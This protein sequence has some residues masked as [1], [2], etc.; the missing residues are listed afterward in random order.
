MVEMKCGMCK[1]QGE[2]KVG[3][4]SEGKVGGKKE[5]GRGIGRKGWN[6]VV[7]ER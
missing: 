7:V 2:G 5:H 1:K 6:L 3:E 4:E